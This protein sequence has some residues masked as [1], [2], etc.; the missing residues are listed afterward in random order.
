MN[1]IVRLGYDM[2]RNTNVRQG[3]MQADYQIRQATLSDANELAQLRWAFSSP[4]QQTAQ[5]LDE[6]RGPFTEY[7]AEALAE[8]WVIWVAESAGHIVGNMYVQLVDKLPR[9]GRFGHRWG[10]VTNVYVIPEMRNTGLGAE[11]MEHVQAWAREAD[12]E[13]LLLWPSERAVPFY[14]RTGFALEQDA[15]IWELPARG[16]RQ[17]HRDE[18]AVHDAQ[19]KTDGA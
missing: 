12:L 11:L 2:E 15:L 9:P 1:E 3:T 5:P 6:F 8:G 10:Y 7:I 4:T 16:N 19:P 14:Q 18:P 13:F 17:S